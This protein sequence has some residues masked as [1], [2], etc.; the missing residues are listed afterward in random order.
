[1]IFFFRLDNRLY[2]R[3]VFWWFILWLNMKKKMKRSRSASSRTD[4][5][6]GFLWNRPPGQHHTTPLTICTMHCSLPNMEGQNLKKN[7]STFF[8]ISY[9]T[10]IHVFDL[11]PII[12]SNCDGESSVKSHSILWWN[13]SL[14]GITLLKQKNIMNW[15]CISFQFLS[16][17]L[18]SILS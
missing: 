15:H 17:T 7:C 1:M 3:L 16:G 12:F 10:S 9:Q 4:F 2:G 6:L 14:R 13:N 18:K 8:K 5:T 11:S